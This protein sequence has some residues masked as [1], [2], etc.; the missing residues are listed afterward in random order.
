[1]AFASVVIDVV[2]KAS[3]KLKA[4]NN[5]ANKSAREFSK[6]DK[7]AGGVTKRFNGL[8]K[9]LTAGALLEVGRRSINTAASFQKLQLRLKLLTE[10]TGEFSEAQ[11]IA[12]RGQKLFGMSATEALDGVT[13]ITARL[14]PLGVSLADI[15]TT[16][17]GFNTAAKLGGASAIEAS[18]AFRQLAQALGSGRLAGDEFRSVSE[19]VPLILKPLAEELNVSTGELKE[20]A[21]Q[22]KLTSDVVIRAL[23]KLG[24]SGAE[25]L[26]KILEN[27]PTQVFK[28]LSNEVEKLQIAVGSALLP[29]A[30]ASTEALTILTKVV[31]GLPPE[32]IS[33]AAGLTTVL[34][35]VTLVTPAIKAM[36]VTVA[37]LTKKFVILKTLL[38]GPVIAGIV[39]VGLALN[40]AVNDIKK[41]IDAEKKLTETIENGTVA[42]ADQLIALKEEELQRERTRSA[43]GRDRISR[44]KNIKKIEEEIAALNKRKKSMQEVNEI[45]QKNKT[46]KVGEY[47]YDTASGKAIS[48]PD[49]KQEERKFKAG[50]TDEKAAKT[51][52]ILKQRI[53]IKQQENDIDRQLLERQFEFQNKMEE[54]MGIEDEGLRLEKSRLLLKDYQI[55]RQEIL[56]QKV[57]DQV[58]ISKEL[59][60]T[61]EQGL[62]ENIKGA[63]NGT[64]TFGQAMGN[65]LNSLKNKL[66][67][68]ALSNLF[69]GI[70]DA[71]FGDGEKN[72]GILGG[73]LGGIFGKKAQ[74]GPVVGGRSYLVG[75]RGPEIFTPRGSGGITPNNQ[76]GGSV[77]INVNVDAGGTDVEGSDTKGN[78]LGQQIAIA[79]Q[80]EII[81]Q[82]RAGGLLAN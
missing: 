10:A 37:V 4:I 17:I 61:L 47:T 3:N 66:M 58:N 45:M 33:I 49:I 56:N 29:A 52:K 68:R 9:A 70:G 40:Y 76:L 38:A 22:G 34:A 28:N 59:G 72:K 36:G 43:H 81:K 41:R 42:Q 26:K 13:N 80:S 79:I 31:N 82:K 67:D 35:T 12:T 78:E 50:S 18:N 75:E 23:R 60:D 51:I 11:K 7:R 64:Q 57:K 30:K 1:M 69:G 71:V 25:D 8:A 55:D 53:Q 15:E 19:Q 54:A 39:A 6:L 20:L 24:A 14:K 74:G 73:F 21:A 65:V 16:F 2:D 62:V 27:D 5:Q 77:N 46:Y 44:D 32:F 48:G 63:I